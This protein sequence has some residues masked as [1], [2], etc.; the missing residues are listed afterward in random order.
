MP[1]NNNRNKRKKRDQKFIIPEV[2]LTLFTD[3]QTTSPSEITNLSESYLTLCFKFPK[4]HENDD[5]IATFGLLSYIAHRNKHP[6]KVV[7]PT[8]RLHGEITPGPMSQ[9]MH[10]NCNRGT[11]HVHMVKSQVNELEINPIR[12]SRKELITYLEELRKV[13]LKETMVEYLR[14]NPRIRPENLNRIKNT[15]LKWEKLKVTHILPPQVK[16]SYVVVSSGM[17]QNDNI[18]PEYINFN[19][20]KNPRI[21]TTQK[22]PVLPFVAQQSTSQMRTIPTLSGP[23]NYG[24]SLEL[25]TATLSSGLLILFCFLGRCRNKVKDCEPK[26]NT[27]S[28]RM[29]AT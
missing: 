17:K 26:K 28:Y 16:I 25:I 11:D 7:L 22:Y 10:L 29:K 13:D 19:N 8:H 12:F 14:A 24:I 23:N 21:G 2:T 9:L 5:N 6:F 1:T 27:G 4:R 20:L 18:K 3:D 15:F